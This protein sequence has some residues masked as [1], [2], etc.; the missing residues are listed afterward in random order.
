MTMKS[1]ALALCAV[2]TAVPAQVCGQTIN[3][4]TDMGAFNN[5]TNATA[6]TKAF[7]NAFFNYPNG[8]IIVPPGNY[9]IDNSQGA[10]TITNFNGELKF[11]GSAILLFQNNI[12]GGFRFLGGTGMRIEGMH[13][14]YPN[15]P[16][17]R[18]GTEFSFTGSVD[19]FVKDITA[20]NSPGAAIM[21]TSC[22]RPK[23]INAVATN[24]IADGFIFANSQDAQLV[25]LTTNHTLDNGLALYNYLI[26]D[27]LHGATISNVRVTN[28]Y[29]H[30]IAVV[31][32]SHVT[33]SGFAVDK[34]RGSAVFIGQDPTY[35]TRISDQ[36][37]VE[38]GYVR[39][40]G[41]L[42]P[43]GGTTFGLEYNQ[44]VSVVFSDIQVEGSNGRSVSGMGP[45]SRVYLR[46]VRAKGNLSSDDFVFYK[47]AY[48]DVMNCSSENSTGAGF[49]FN[50]VNSV[51]ARRLTS[52]NSSRSSSL[53][54]AMWFQDNGY[55]NA[56]GLLVVDNQAVP[57]GFIV[58]TSNSPGL[59][60]AGSI[61]GVASGIVHG[62]LRIQNYASGTHFSGVN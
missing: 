9:A 26:Y 30:G 16:T 36:V 56:G 38:H 52:I 20:E 57:T 41:T 23:V 49:I 21:F 59:T 12:Q 27:D 28:S 46:N 51:V 60:E 2:F 48:A 45:S 3:M 32:T 24:S 39:G 53:N 37:T 5:G 10:I 62:T 4:V 18:A 42:N 55:V 34:T 1:L 44:P 61:Q 40:S 35:Q 7:Q 15:A 8:K 11:E 14:N 50:A 58:G 29:A 43:P 6:N 25:N 33:I 31:G 19:A 13:G 47:T 17:Q 22:I 54:R